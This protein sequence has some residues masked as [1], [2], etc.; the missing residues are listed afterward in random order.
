MF[1][2]DTYDWGQMSLP[3]PL[4]PMQRPTSSPLMDFI[5]RAKGTRL[6]PPGPNNRPSNFNWTLPPQGELVPTAGGEN[7][8]PQGELVPT[9]AGPRGSGRPKAPPGDMRQTTLPIGP[10]IRSE[11]PNVPPSLSTLNQPAFD[12]NAG[13]P[14][15]VAPTMAPDI[16]MGE[17]E[18]QVRSTSPW[19]TLAALGFGMAASK[20][21]H[22]FGA[23]GE[24]GQEALKQ[25]NEQRKQAREESSSRLQQ[26]QLGEIMRRNQ[27]QEN[28]EQ[29]GQ[30]VQL[31]N[32]DVQHQI[33]LLNYQLSKEE[34]PSKIALLQ[35]QSANLNDMIIKDVHGAS[36]FASRASGQAALQ[37]AN[38]NANHIGSLIKH[39]DES[40]FEGQMKIHSQMNAIMEDPNASQ[41][42]KDY[43]Q[44]FMVK[45]LG[46][47]DASS[48][49]ALNGV[50]KNTD[51]DAL[52]A[53]AAQ[54]L[55]NIAQDHADRM[56]RITGKDVGTARGAKGT[57]ENPIENPT[58]A[59]VDA[60][61]AGT[62]FRVNGKLFP[63]K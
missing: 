39:A 41:S 31:H 45:F 12:I 56:A 18:A 37:N 28:I 25:L 3:L 30:D 16:G 36:A 54:G 44:A 24:G 4:R 59:Q 21:P 26:L 19:T 13:R 43:A 5:N 32:A 9:P 63:K 6:Q 47:K 15:R 62:I 57:R 2:D 48:V 7:A 17:Q 10:D 60:A 52:K 51:D 58:Q 46:E 22:I 38:T 61:A 20:N 49:A 33:Q 11:D 29:R 34:S 35:A 55:M 14:D 40:T 50:M 42:R 23:V 8:P 53:Q 27:S 1:D